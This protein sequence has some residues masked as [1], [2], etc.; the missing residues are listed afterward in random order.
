M[1]TPKGESLPADTLVE[2]F[3]ADWQPIYD[4]VIVKKM[5]A[6]EKRLD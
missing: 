1:N 5:G 6:F 2:P 3:T 4:R